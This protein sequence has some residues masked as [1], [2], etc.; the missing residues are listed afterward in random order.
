M[1]YVC[2]SVMV[3]FCLM[4]M[5]IVESEC[6]LLFSVSFSVV[7]FVMC[8]FDMFKGCFSV[9]V[10]LFGFICG[11]LFVMFSLCSVVIFWVVKVLFSLIMLKLVC[12]RFSC[13]SSF[14]LVGV[15]LMF[16]MCGG[17]FVVVLF[18][19]WVMGVRLCFFVVLVVVRI[20]VVVLL[21]MFEVLFVVML[22]LLN[23]GCSLV[24]VLGVVVW[25]CLLWFMISGLFLCCGMLIGVILCVRCLFVCVVVVLVCEVSVM[26]FCV[27]CEML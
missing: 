12:V 13:V 3:I 14:W 9:M 11:L 22:L 20:S 15:G 24:S 2:F 6:L 7:V 27:L 16:M 4:L 8:V 10:L 5:Y 19:M 25:G 26:V 23:S 17:M 21:L 18:R 1:D